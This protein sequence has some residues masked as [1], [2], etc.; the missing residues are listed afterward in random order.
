MDAYLREL[1]RLDRRF[2]SALL[3]GWAEEDASAARP[4]S[5]ARSADAI[6]DDAAPRGEETP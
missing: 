4:S 5:S 2:T 6:P 3:P 1:S